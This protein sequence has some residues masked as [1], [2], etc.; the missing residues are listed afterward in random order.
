[1]LPYRFRRAGYVRRS[2]KVL[3][4]NLEVYEY[5]NMQSLRKMFNNNKEEEKM[6]ITLKLLFIYLDNFGSSNS[7]DAISFFDPHI[8]VEA[9][10]L[11]TGHVKSRVAI[12]F[13]ALDGCPFA[14]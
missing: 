11:G 5:G 2:L 10:K 12:R 4:S 8:H 9:W 14:V 3:D 1:M 13:L 6:T 7:I